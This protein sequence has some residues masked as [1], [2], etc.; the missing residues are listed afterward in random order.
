MA[1][2]TSTCMV[3]L[4]STWTVSLRAPT[5]P[6][7]RLSSPPGSR[8]WSTSKPQRCLESRCRC[9]CSSAPTSC[10]NDGVDGP[11][12]ASTCQA[13]VLA[14]HQEQGAIHERDYDDWP[15]SS[16][17]CFSGS[18]HWCR[19]YDGSAQ[20]TAARSSVGVLQPH[21]TLC[22]RAGSVCDGALLGARAGRA[23]P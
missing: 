9:L 1:P 23:W 11:L 6:I 2:T 4:L 10:S 18:R 21:S 19:G 13:G 3:E 14:N 5:P 17:A 8:C 7:S 20:A 22:G 12:A 15:G 16:Q